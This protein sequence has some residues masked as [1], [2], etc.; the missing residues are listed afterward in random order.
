MK[1]VHSSN[2]IRDNALPWKKMLRSIFLPDDM[3]NGIRNL[4]ERTRSLN[5]GRVDASNGRAPH[6]NT[7]KTTPRD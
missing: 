4:P 7:Y 2:K 5:A 1:I 6:T 3:K